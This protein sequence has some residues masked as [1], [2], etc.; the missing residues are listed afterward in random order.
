MASRLALGLLCV[1]PLLS[2]VAEAPGDGIGQSCNLAAEC[3]LPLS[4]VQGKEG[5]RTCQNVPLPE[6]LV[7]EANV[8]F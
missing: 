6:K 7:I 4:C 5:A 8:F 3:P 2:C 1:L